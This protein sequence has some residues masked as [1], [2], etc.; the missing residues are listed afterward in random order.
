M[1]HETIGYKDAR[2]IDATDNDESVYGDSRMDL[3]P[4]H[5]SKD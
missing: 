5:H 1:V 3:T 2:E 4:Y